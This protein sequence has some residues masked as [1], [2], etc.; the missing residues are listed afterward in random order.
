MKDIEAARAL[1]WASFGV[2]ATE[3]L[4]EGT[5]EQD[6]LGIDKHPLLMIALGLREAVSGATILTQKEITPTL[7]AGLW[8]RVAGD[9]MDIALLTLAATRTRRPGGLALAAASVLGLTV[10]DVYYA[11]RIQRRL[12]MA[13]YDVKHRAA[14]DESTSPGAQPPP[15]GV[16]AP[17]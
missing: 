17:V 6:L 5:V 7:A 16:P 11:V 2:A 15:Q 10:A 9:A 4:G 12:L 8:A 3:I 13:E 14:L 1:G